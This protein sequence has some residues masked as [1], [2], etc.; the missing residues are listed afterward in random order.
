[1]RL[2]SHTHPYPPES[3][4]Q[5][6]ETK[7]PADG[8]LERNPPP[9]EGHLY[10]FLCSMFGVQRNK[11]GPPHHHHDSI[12]YILGFSEPRLPRAVHRKRARV[13]KTQTI[14][15]DYVLENTQTWALQ[16]V[17]ASSP[18]RGQTFPLVMM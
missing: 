2:D 6:L 15:Q 4:Q 7:A 10:V 1:M 3:K 16:Q 14:Y 11:K 18:T 17:Q 9:A 12:S 5:A 13:C 8:V